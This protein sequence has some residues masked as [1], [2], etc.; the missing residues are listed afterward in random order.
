MADGTT[1][2]TSAQV[3]NEADGSANVLSDVAKGSN[4]S[5]EADTEITLT[6][7]G[8]TASMEY[9][10]WVVLEYDHT[11]PSSPTL[12][13]ISTDKTAPTVAS[14]YPSSSNIG[15]TDLTLAVKANENST[16]YFVVLADGATRP[17][18]TEIINGQDGSGAT[19]GVKASGNIT[20]KALS[21]IHI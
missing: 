9:D 15:Q 17:D 1:A 21:L 13:E 12:V 10:L 4:D 5:V 3:K 18:T 7:S 20:L 19:S 2:P 11:L 14:G 6:I 16:A 8:L